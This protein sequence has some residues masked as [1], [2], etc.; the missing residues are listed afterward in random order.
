MTQL[1]ERPAM[2]RFLP[3]DA[4]AD[5]DPPVQPRDELVGYPNLSSI[6]PGCLRSRLRAAWPNEVTAGSRTF[7][8][9]RL[10][11][12]ALWDYNAARAHYLRWVDAGQIENAMGFADRLED[13]INAT[14]RGLRSLKAALKR[15]AEQSVDSGRALR[16]EL[17]SHKARRKALRQVRTEL[18]APDH[19]AE[20][21]GPARL[22]FDHTGCA[23][24]E[25]T[26]RFTD[27]GILV[28]TL[29]TIIGEMRTDV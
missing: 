29:H 25:S 28:R 10:G 16:Q 8:L 6:P 13:C 19:L 20:A 4:H 18:Y 23:V 21:A 11:E 17:R 9:V 2:L 14:D 5:K 24:G 12:K 26:L 22:S 3:C 1:L 15:P 7:E 27:L